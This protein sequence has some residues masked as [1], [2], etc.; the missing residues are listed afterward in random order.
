MTTKAIKMINLGTGIG[1]ISKLLY[2]TSQNYY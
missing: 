2:S 1:I